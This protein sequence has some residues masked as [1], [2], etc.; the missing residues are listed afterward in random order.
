[1]NIIQNSIIYIVSILFL[2]QNIQAQYIVSLIEDVDN[3]SYCNGT[4]E[5]NVDSST[6]PHTYL[7]NTGATTKDLLGVCVGIYTVTV[8]DVNG[9]EWALEATVNRSGSWCN[10][11]NEDFLFY[12]GY[13]CTITSAP[14]GTLEV[15]FLNIESPIEYIYEWSNGATT[16]PITELSVGTYSVTIIDPLVPNCQRVQHFN[17]SANNNSSCIPAPAH[18]H[19]T[20]NNETNNT[21]NPPIIVNEVSSRKQNW[22]ASS[23]DAEYIELLVVGDGTCNDV[24]IRGFIIDDNNGDFSNPNLFKYQTG[25]AQGHNRF[26]YID[27]WT[28]VPLGSRI[29]LYNNYNKDPSITLANDPTDANNDNIY[30]LPIND[31]GIEG[32]GSKPRIS[33]DSYSNVGYGTG[34][35]EYIKLRNK[36]DAAQIRYPDG[37]YCHGFSYDIS[38]NKMTGG[39]DNLRIPHSGYGRVF[40][41]KGGDYKNINNYTITSV[42]NAQSQTPGLSNNTQNQQFTQDL[43]NE[44]GPNNPPVI[45]NEFSSGEDGTQQEYIELLV[46]GNGENCVFDMRG[47]IIDDNNGDY[48]NQIQGS[49]ISAGHLKFPNYSFY[50]DVPVGSLIVIYNN[51]DKNPLIGEQDVSDNDEDGVYI[52]SSAYLKSNEFVPSFIEPYDYQYGQLVYESHS[53][54]WGFIAGFNDHDAIQV[55]YPNGEYCHGISYG[56]NST[57]INGGSDDLLIQEASSRNKNYSFTTGEAKDKS[58]FLVGMF[59]QDETPGTPNNTANS[60]Y[61]EDLNNCNNTYTLRKTH[62][63]FNIP[64]PPP[65]IFPNP[66]TSNIT[67]EINTTNTKEVIE[68]ELKDIIGKSVH[69]NTTILIRG[70]NILSIEPNRNLAQGV[71]YL[72]ITSNGETLYSEKVICLK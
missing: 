68:I 48:S 61:I 20:Y 31:S 5:L 25:I 43:L 2:T 52:I 40:S 18:P 24:D 70:K 65:K 62:L 71:Y 45:I 15:Q 55:R 8:T 14:E 50:N 17:V 32:A 72:S 69:Q 51:R 67:I 49:G 19:D 3:N 66:F 36:Q 13:D 38:Q 30:I 57:Y 10:L 41:F 37:T 9:C 16:N 64:Q 21:Q 34:S 22:G 47:F 6:A 1:M 35:W 54:A 33:N 53:L 56:S 11:D 42:T 44:C 4:V 26:K 23:M 60:S 12:N 46:V 27:R 7:W 28:N 39:P 63:N 59:D 29:L 58:N